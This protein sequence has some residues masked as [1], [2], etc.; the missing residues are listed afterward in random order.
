ML[1]LRAYEH[2]LNN[3]E[4]V[5]EFYPT[6]PSVVADGSQIQQALLNLLLNAEQAMRGRSP[7][8]LR[9]GTRYDDAAAAVGAVSARQPAR[10]AG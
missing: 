2:R 7:K 3:V 9:V 8:R 6:L 10:K 1:A 4:L 5:P